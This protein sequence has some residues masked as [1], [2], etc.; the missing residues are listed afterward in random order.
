M[1]AAHRAH[2]LA[3]TLLL[4]GALGVGCG[5]DDAAGTAK[6]EATP[7]AATTAEFC[8]SYNSLYDAF[9]AGTQPS[10][11]EAVAAIKEWAAGLE[12]TGAPAD[13]PAEAEQGLELV[14][15]TVD[16][17]RPDADQAEIQKLSDD[18]DAE[19]QAQSEAFG[20]YASKTCPMEAPTEAPS[21]SP[22]K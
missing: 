5:G 7:S 10:D 11:E 22:T 19:Q 1:R 8:A 12:S 13:M 21:P 14:T 9:P 17:I 15:A 6:A 3:A 18:M 16:K 20:T 2:L 4:T